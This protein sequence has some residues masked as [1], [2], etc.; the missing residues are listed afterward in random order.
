[1]NKP[2]RPETLGER[3]VNYIEDMTAFTCPKEVSEC[4]Q[5]E[6][7]KRN[8]C[9]LCL[10]VCDI[11]PSKEV[12]K[13]C[14][15]CGHLI[16]EEEK[17]YMS[18]PSVES[19]PKDLTATKPQEPMEW[20]KSFRNKFGRFYISQNKQAEERER[21]RILDLT[22]YKNDDGVKEIEKGKYYIKVD[23]IINRS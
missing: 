19:T 16:G 2:K 20:R 9:S 4:C 11:L 14:E 5:S 7:E 22:Y 15:T 12:S 8:V 3:V 10:S 6:V 18:I 1:M 17:L 21:N 23:D 13:Y